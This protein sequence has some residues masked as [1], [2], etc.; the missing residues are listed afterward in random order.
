MAFV[1]S[2]AVPNGIDPHRS[3]DEFFPPGAQELVKNVL[4]KHTAVALLEYFH[5]G[6]SC[7]MLIMCCGECIAV[8][9]SHV[10]AL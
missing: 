7:L 9:L 3:E 2:T 10:K 8:I 1:S 4:R 5:H 6:M